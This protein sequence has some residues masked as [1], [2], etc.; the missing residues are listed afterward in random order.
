MTVFAGVNEVNHRSRPRSAAARGRRPEGVHRPA[1]PGLR[2]PTTRRSSRQ[3][4]RSA[5]G[6]RIIV[7]N[8]PEHRRRCR[9]SRRSAARQRQAA[10]RAV[11]G[12]DDDG[13][14]MSLTS[15]GVTVVDLMC[16]SRSY[17]PSNYSSDGF[18]P[19]DAGYAFI[20]GN[21][22]RHH[23]LVSGAPRQLRADERRSLRRVSGVE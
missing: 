8:L 16:D 2:L 22:Q 13:Q 15:Q 21:R 12:H 20:A 3:S 9:I 19:N 4:A 7:L 18:H 23:V 6:T 17:L 10:Q 5:P 14:S 11:G 1:G